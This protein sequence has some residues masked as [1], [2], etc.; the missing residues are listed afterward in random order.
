MSTKS[1]KCDTISLPFAMRNNEHGLRRGRDVLNSR[2]FLSSEKKAIEREDR[3]R[4]HQ[5]GGVCQRTLL[6][7]R[8]CKPRLPVRHDGIC[9]SPEKVQI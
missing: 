8:G 2:L 7:V 6:H 9:G 3:R 4:T 1:E 5:V